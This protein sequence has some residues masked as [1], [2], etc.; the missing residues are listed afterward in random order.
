MTVTRR[1]LLLRA[2]VLAAPAVLTVHA[3][4]EVIP[5]KVAVFVAHLCAHVAGD[6][7]G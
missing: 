6:G 7:A 3:R 5:A 1:H 4:Q 2:A